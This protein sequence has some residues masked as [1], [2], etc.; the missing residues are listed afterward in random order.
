[1]DL[2]FFLQ[3]GVDRLVLE[4]TGVDVI[5]RSVELMLLKHSSFH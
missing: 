2:A 5:D 1:V 3:A 4:E